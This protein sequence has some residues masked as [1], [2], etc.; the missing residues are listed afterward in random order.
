M[1]LFVISIDTLDIKTEKAERTL[2]ALGQAFT[3]HANNIW[4][5]MFMVKQLSIQMLG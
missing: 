5:N 4:V 3:R 1:L 2:S